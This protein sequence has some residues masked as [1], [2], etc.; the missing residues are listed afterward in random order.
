MS[1]FTCTSPCKLNLFL[2]ITG[3]RPDGYHNL[4][5]LFV[6][7]DY[8]DEM[9]FE[10][11]ED[12]K[13]TCEPDMGIPA[14]KNLIL[15]AASVLKERMGTPL[16]AKISI[17]KILPQGGGLGGGSGNA[18]TVLLVLNRLWDLKL[19][20]DELIAMAARLGADVPVFV[21]GMPAFGEGIGEILTEVSVPLKWYLVCTPE[22][23]H[24]PTPKLFSHA[25]L[26]KDSPI[27]SFEELCKR[28]FENCFTPVVTKEYPQV[29]E[30][31]KTLSQFGPA[32]MSGSG[33]SCFVAF[34]G[35]QE[36]EAAMVTITSKLKVSA[37]VSRSVAQSP[38]LSA[39]NAVTR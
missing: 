14:E 28:P 39:L 31:L 11:T 10:V 2:Y 18:G 5:T 7:L 13:V 8:G 25:A 30:L 37:F 26:K 20:E 12:S 38:V 35:R 9:S 3:R 19:S 29:A 22:G 27:L 1:A 16:G 4:Q 24:V 21:K 6:I 32:F 17:K 36:A 23:C 34:D 15:R 33:S